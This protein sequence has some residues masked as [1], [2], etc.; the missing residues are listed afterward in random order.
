MFSLFLIIVRE[1][2]EGILVVAVIMAT[3]KKQG[4][5]EEARPF[6]F[7]GS[8]AGAA[9]S[10]ALGWG[11]YQLS[12]WLE[13]RAIVAFQAMI[14]LVAALLMTHMVFWMRRVG[15]QVNVALAADVQQ[16]MSRRGYVGVSSVTALAMGREGGEA[17]VYIYTMT[18][19]Q[20]VSG[21]V[22]A[23]TCL[24]ALAAS[25]VIAWGI[26]RG[27]QKIP[28]K[29]VFTISSV[30]LL[31]SA[32]RLF[33]DAAQRLTEL[34]YLPALG[35]F[36][37]IVFALAIGALFWWERHTLS[38]SGAALAVIALLA[39]TVFAATAARAIN[40][41]ELEV[42]PYQT[43]GDGSWEIESATSF[44]NGK[45]GMN[46]GDTV[47]SSLEIN[48][49]LT[50]TIDVAGY[51]DFARLTPDEDAKYHGARLRGR[52]SPLAKGEWPV[53]VGAYLEVAKPQDE[54][55]K[56]EVEMRAIIEVDFNRVTLSVNPYIELEQEKELKD[57]GIELKWDVE[58]GLSAGLRYNDFPHARPSLN[59]FT[60]I[61]PGSERALLIMPQI[62]T[63]PAPHWEL[64][65]GL[66]IGL[67]N[68]TE[69]RL[70]NAKVAYEF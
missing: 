33:N 12:D 63:K 47:R 69:R 57:D 51:V 62:D 15:K 45:S 36:V 53:D 40:Y 44:S 2:L 27:A 9:L 68:A 52:Y 64:G 32:A 42:Y 56:L 58:K 30:V 3:M 6:I 22:I 61:K 21:A 37:E 60:D 26:I 28:M 54:I 49:G 7:A 17:A 29:A 59:L 34:D 46:V 13:G 5:A 8:L 48:R 50:D 31:I 66:G 1:F 18:T 24:M 70:L 43:K 4:L 19:G 23:L 14:S 20:N 39:V 38:R 67:T 55:K 16:A 11:L 65:L 25:C 41:S 10:L 35:H